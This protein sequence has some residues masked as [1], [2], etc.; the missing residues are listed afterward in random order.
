MLR[1]IALILLAAMFVLTLSNATAAAGSV[2][3]MKN[4]ATDPPVVKA[5]PL[6]SATAAPPATPAPAS[7]QPERDPATYS[8]PLLGTATDSPEPTPFASGARGDEVANVQIRLKELGFLNGTSDGIFGPMTENAVKTLKLYLHE[9]E[10]PVSSATS[11]SDGASA[12]ESVPVVLI[13][14]PGETADLSTPESVPEPT[15]PPYEPDGEVTDELYDLLVNGNIQNF[16]E[17]MSKGSRGTEVTRLQTRLADLYYITTGIDGIFGGNTEQALKYFQKRNG[18]IEDGVASITVQKILFSDMAVI[19]DKPLTPYKLKVS[20]SD[21][22]VYVYEWESGSY[23]RLIKSMDCST[24]LKATPTPHGTFTSTT[25]P[26]K[27]WHYFT[28]FDCWAQY[29]YYIKGDI[30][31]HSVLYSQKDENT[32]QKSS[33]RNLGKRASH[34]CVRLSVDNAKWIYNNCPAGTTVVVY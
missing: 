26:G 8:N 29:A 31:F 27:R 9:L 10:N 6:P 23:S 32:L 4:D 20:V 22:K 24:G 1:R 15:P 28:K 21:Q 2:N 34:G 17:E 14:S 12:D 16:R 19:S 11:G 5:T 13:S 30:M 7:G 18:L 33:V 25:G 3:P